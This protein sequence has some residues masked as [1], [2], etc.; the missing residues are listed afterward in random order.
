MLICC[1][2]L[3]YLFIV[4]A[5]III[6]KNRDNIR[7]HRK[8]SRLLRLSVKRNLKV[9]WQRCIKYSAFKYKYK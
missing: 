6:C 5:I 8:L 7:N 2:E 3:I 9:M 4:V 1:S